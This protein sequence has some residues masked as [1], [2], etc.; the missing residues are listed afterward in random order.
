LPAIRTVLACGPLFALF[1]G[2]MDGRSNPQSLERAVEDAVHMKID[3]ASVGRG[4][5]AKSL[6]RKDPAH[7][8]D[9]K[10]LVGLHF[11]ALASRV[12]LQSPARGV[13]RFFDRNAQIFARRVDLHVLRH[14]C[15]AHLAQS[16]AQRGRSL[17]DDLAARERQIDAHPV[18]HS[19]APVPVRNLDGHPATHDRLVE[20]FKL[21][22]LRM[23]PLLDVFRRFQIAKRNLHGR[24][25]WRAPCHNAMHSTRASSPFSTAARRA[26]AVPS[27]NMIN[28]GVPLGVN[29]G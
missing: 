21:L 27:T 23:N 24:H 1:F 10:R 8:R 25:H 26:A 5:K 22:G 9:G 12:V 11:P 16:I 3:F 20:R 18:N 14:F 28:L 13:E 7:A 19:P 17:Y 4:E 15:L 6:V 2:K 29:Y